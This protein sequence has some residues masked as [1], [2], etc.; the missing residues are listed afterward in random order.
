MTY[1]FSGTIDRVIFENTSNFFKIILLEIDD[2]D[3]DFDDF[4]IIVTGTIAD[5]IEGENY[6]F[7]GELTQHPKYGQQLKVER[8]QRAKP[9]SAGL[10]KYFSSQHF[11]G[12]GKKTAEKIIHLYG[13]DPI[14][15]ILE[16]PDKLESISGLSKANRENLVSKLRLNYGAEQILAKLAEY[17]L[18]NKTAVQIFERYKEESL[19]VI[20]ENP[21][22]LVEDIQG[23]GFKMADKLAEQV[24]INS[25]APQRF[26]AALVH[27][28]LE[29]SIDKGDTYIE[30]KELLEKSLF[31]LEEVRQVE[32]D[33]SQIAQEL[34]QLISEDKV[35][36][37][38]TKIFD[39]TLFYAESG[40]H[41]HLT[42]ILDRPLEKEI[43]SQ[44]IQT[45]IKHIQAEF[46]INYDKAQKNAIQKAIQ[47]KVF[48]LTGGPGTG[49]TTVINGII[50]AYANLH[51]IDLQKS[52][53]PIILAAPTGRA[54]RR[55][56]ELT[57]LPSAT[58]HRHLG[59]NGDSEYQAL[60]DFLDCD[61]IIIDEFS[62]VDTWLAN[63]L[64]SA[65]AS[66]TQVIIV[67]DSDQLPS[68]GPGQI[69]A[70]LLKINRLPQVSL[71]K[72]FRQS[73]DSTIV[74]LANQIRQGRLPT[75][76]T[77]K[78]ADR[79][80][81]EAQST[82]IPQMIQK[83]VSSA[84][85]SGIDAQEIQILAPMYRGQAGI[86]HLN[87]LMQD[88]LNPLNNQLEFQFNDLHFRKG[89]KVLHLINDAQINVFNGD[90][91]YITDLI[92]AKYTESK[93]DEMI[94]DFDGT[95]INYPRNE[96]LKITLA[97]AMSI[98]KSQG[99]EF[100]V[101]ILPVTRQS[102]RLLQRNLIYT[103]ITRSKSKLVMLGEI[104]AFD[105]AIKNEGTK[106]KTYLIERFKKDECSGHHNTEKN[107]QGVKESA[108]ILKEDFILTERNI[109]TIDPMIG[110]SQADIDLFFK[111]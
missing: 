45:E 32:L 106:R 35:Q 2:T 30:A 36:N 81:F 49:K 67:G 16:D 97:Y 64:F 18:N 46:N 19:T 107:K 103:A 37:I 26:R 65:I 44:D 111:K 92:P 83:I 27:T 40:I 75:D 108:A 6:T 20:T 29:T 8:Y 48:L 98:H 39:N 31:I 78:K 70:D 104:A 9:S 88:L 21:Y 82:H 17:G 3:S 5:V 87:K 38:G 25:D 53:R 79:S 101:V 59:L 11:K 58:I 90:I 10:I 109:L 52:D 93:Q 54:A 89:D 43:S 42:R 85:K 7:W 91:G 86:T 23:I 69:L 15:N 61:L 84:L 56:N 71:T 28:L 57:G 102:G 105:N 50:K 110:L 77:A 73:E 41:K 55:M 60:D 24:G 99:S 1:Y 100:K 47:S 96:W 74:T 51:Q 72:I 95:E 63:Q 76:F 62:M 34:T 68:V 33:P 22:Q 4:E 13:D 66:N 14:D 80:Y 94:L 12:I